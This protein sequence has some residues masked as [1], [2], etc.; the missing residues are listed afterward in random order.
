MSLEGQTSDNK[1]LRKTFW[2]EEVAGGAYECCP[3]RCPL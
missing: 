3:K 2:Q 1:S